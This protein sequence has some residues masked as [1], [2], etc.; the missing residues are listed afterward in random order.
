[1]KYDSIDGSVMTRS[2][3]YIVIESIYHYRD[4]AALQRS[5]LLQ[6]PVEWTGEG[7]T[8]RESIELLCVIRKKLNIKSLSLKWKCALEVSRP[9]RV[10]VCVVDD[11]LMIDDHELDCWL[12][13][14]RKEHKKT[15]KFL[16][17]KIH[18]CPFRGLNSL[19]SEGASRREY[20]HNLN[21][22]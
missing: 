21:K 14:A 13:A 16:A 4:T 17:R 20:H 6:L 15:L 22:S 12:K 11:S 5:A 19:T 2:L 7:E 1:M 18:N 3:K 10:M 8:Y 9:L